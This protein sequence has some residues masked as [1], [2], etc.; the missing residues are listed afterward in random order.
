MP[1]VGRR[2]RA[3]TAGSRRASSVI[4][5]TRDVRLVRGGRSAAG[6]AAP[7]RPE[8]ATTRWVARTRS[9]SSSS[10]SI[11]PR[12][13]TGSVLGVDGELSAAAEAARVAG[14]G[15]RRR[16]RRP[17][18]PPRAPGRGTGR[19]A[20]CRGG[21]RRSGRGPRPGG[22]AAAP[23]RPVR[24]DCSW[25]P[26]IHRCRASGAV[27]PGPAPGSP[28]TVSAGGRAIL[29][30][31]SRISL[32][33]FH[34]P[35]RRFIPVIPVNLADRRARSSR[36]KVARVNPSHQPSL[37]PRPSREPLL[38]VVIVN[39]NSWPDVAPAGRR[40]WPAT[41][42]V[43]AGDCEV[44]VVDNA[45][46]GPVPTELA[47]PRPGRP[48][49]RPAR[50]R[51]LR[52][53]RQ[54][55]LA[56]RA[57]SLAPGAQPGRRG[58]GRAARPGRRPG[59]AVRGRAGPAA[60]GVVGFGLRNPDGSRQPSVGAFPNLARTVWEQLIPRSRRKYQAGWRIRPGPGRLGHGGLHAGQR[61]AARR[62][63]AGWTRSSSSITRRSPSAGRPAD[64]GWRVEYDPAVEVVHLHPLQNRPIS[65]KMRVITRHSKLLYFRKHLPRW[66]F[67]GPL[68]DRR[69]RGD[70]AGA[71]CDGPGTGRGTVGRG[72][73]SARWRGPSARGPSRVGRDVLDAGRGGHGTRAPRRRPET[74]GGG[75]IDRGS[76]RQ[77]S[78]GG[79]PAGRSSYRE[80]TDPRVADSAWSPHRPPDGRRRG[81][82][83]LA[84]PPLRGHLRRRPA[85]HPPGR[86]DRPRRPGR[87]ACSGRSTTRSTRWRSPRR[88]GSSAARGPIAWQRA[89]QARRSR[90]ASCW[91]SRSTW[92]PWR[93][94]AR[95]RAW[96]GAPAGG[97]QSR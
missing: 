46:D 57:G 15:R 37:D 62:R 81:P 2:R 23:R 45:S 13:G 16:T 10:R 6:A 61:P 18:G 75:P 44:V 52:R 79:R 17:A 92:S 67:A 30:P 11:P 25:V 40:R 90:P 68:P 86:A 94:T 31:P 3:A 97:R 93:S 47:R 69:G 54:R 24:G 70:G 43:A 55:R 51:R 59:R 36:W 73:R 96:L 83:R 9:T 38:T 42:E 72:G 77:G 80:R 1:V 85:L 60:P 74:A 7:G 22:P 95:R 49:G 89:A 35:D 63:W 8:T 58:P 64:R 71:W 21:R 27:A 66:Q 14:G 28:P 56:G 53:R 29:G 26:P 50:E 19:A 20:G 78:D 5:W 4:Q 76:A 84:E 32:K 91:S 48:A 88:T 87:T 12:T 41:P 65:P 33:L 39:Y 82:V 34:R